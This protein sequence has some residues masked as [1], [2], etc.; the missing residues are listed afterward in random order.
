MLRMA[1]EQT[2]YAD[3]RS[4]YSKDIVWRTVPRLHKA[5]G[6]NPAEQNRS[7]PVLLRHVFSPQALLLT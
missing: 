5:L 2:C 4:F 7:Y 3:D 1:E 6:R